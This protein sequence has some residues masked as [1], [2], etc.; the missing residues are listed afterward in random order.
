M[1]SNSKLAKVLSFLTKASNEKLDEVM[2]ALEQEETSS[3]PK[4][5]T[6]NF[7]FTN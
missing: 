6:L 4:G 7:C 3:A 1:S 5:I 2:A